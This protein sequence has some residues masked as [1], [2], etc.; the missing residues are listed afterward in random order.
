MSTVGN[1]TA[2]DPMWSQHLE[3]IWHSGRNKKTEPLVKALQTYFDKASN[4]FECAFLLMCAASDFHKNR[5]TALSFTIMS[6]FQEWLLDHSELYPTLLTRELKR[7]ALLA[8]LKQTNT[9]LIDLVCRVYKLKDQSMDYMDVV[10]DLLIR[11]HFNEASTIVTALKLQGYFTIEEIAIPLFLMDKMSLLENYV[12][13]L[14]QLQK[15]LL[16]YLDALYNDGSRADAVINTLNVK[17]I[18]KDKIHPKTLAKVISRL[19]KH[20][21]LPSNVCPHVHYHRSK[22]ALKYLMYKRYTEGDFSEA[23]WREMMC[24]AVG[25]NITLKQDLLNELMW[26]RDYEN[27]LSFA[28]KLGLPEHQWPRYLRTFRVQYGQQKVQELLRSWNLSYEKDDPTKYLPLRLDL[29]DV[30]MVDTADGLESC[31]EVIKDYDVV[32]IDAEWKPTMGLTPSRLSLV[33]LAVWDGVYVLDMLKLSNTLSEAQWA[34]LY[35]DVLSSNEILKLGFGIAEDLKL[36]SETIKCPEAKIQN[37]VD[38]CSF[39]EKLRSDH[40]NMMKPVVPKER[41]HKGLSELTRILLGLPLNKDEQ[42]SDW[43][44]R[45]LRQS[46]MKYAALDAFCLLQVYEEL[47]KRAEDEQMNLRDLMEEVKDAKGGETHLRQDRSRKYKSQVGE[48]M[49]CADE[50]FFVRSD[51]MLPVAE[52]RVIAD[53]MVQGLGRYLR[54]CGIDTIILRDGDDRDQAVKLA[55]KESRVILTCGAPYKKMKQYVA[56]EQCFCVNNVA[57]AREQLKDVLK[58]YN[59]VVREKDILTRCT[60]CNASRY[61]L[62]P[63]ADM[64]QLQACLRDEGQAAAGGEPLVRSY[65]PDCSIDFTSGRFNNGKL[66]QCDGLVFEYLSHVETFYVCVACGKVYWDGSHHG[67]FRKQLWLADLIFVEP[68]PGS[69]SCADRVTTTE[70]GCCHQSDGTSS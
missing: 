19:L 55:Q 49:T 54:L 50:C 29:C 61:A 42:C 4:S 16:A 70:T 25:N 69:E 47:Y 30:H 37:V 57:S 36:L 60:E 59:V 5:P 32:G 66:V 58:F 48:E 56:R 67:R 6:V 51:Q 53:T 43:E 28:L 40:P 2:M 38:L 15:E 12:E 7:R 27:A 8:V 68:S 9:S 18:S 35:T 31:I 20:Y 3:A 14:P 22:S 34:Q 64:W 23:S 33:Q 44:N 10:Q 24:E 13:G 26:V 41:G 21:S 1:A 39:V 45:P 52:F 17:M 65:G 11:K 62:V 63:S 46:Q